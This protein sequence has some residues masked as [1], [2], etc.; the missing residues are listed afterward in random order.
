MTEAKCPICG[1]PTQ[2]PFRPFCSKRCADIDLQRWLSGRYVVP[3]V[4]EEHGPEDE[5]PDE[6]WARWTSKT[7][8]S[9]DAAPATAAFAWVAQ[10]VEQRI[11]NPRVGG[12]NPPPGTIHLSPISD[13]R[14]GRRIAAG[15][16]SPWARA[17]CPCAL[18]SCLARR[19]RPLR[20]HRRVAAFA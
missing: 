5:A 11:E 17:P 4:E 2:A 7:G 18:S 8:S 19:P 13:V 3:A 9:I 1:R 12:S 16:G 14:A 20:L 15:S 10:L 6:A